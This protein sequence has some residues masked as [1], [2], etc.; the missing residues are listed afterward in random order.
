VG[1]KGTRKSHGPGRA[2]RAGARM[3]KMM[4]GL[5]R[6][7][8][9]MAGKHYRVGIIGAGAIAQACHLPGYVRDGRAT[10]VA[11]ADPVAA[12]HKEVAELWPGVKGYRDYREMLRSE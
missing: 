6:R 1:S 11:F 8:N 5:N 12:R 2:T 9:A 7:R 3:C 4:R 10:V